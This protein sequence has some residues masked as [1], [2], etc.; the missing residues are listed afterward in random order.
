M[1]AI[2]TENAASL[3]LNHL[4]PSAI[5]V[6]ASLKNERETGDL[7]LGFILQRCFLTLVLVFS[8]IKTPENNRYSS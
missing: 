6:L 3:C 5:I 7:G 8:V 2:P 4:I 1:S